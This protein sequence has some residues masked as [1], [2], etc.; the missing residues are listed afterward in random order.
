MKKGPTI[1]F[2]RS[3]K[4]FNGDKVTLINMSRPGQMVN[5]KRS[6]VTDDTNG[7][8]ETIAR[9]LWVQQRYPR[10]ASLP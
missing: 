5:P 2:D 4:R 7:K 10:W 3:R 1:S 9:S 8:G 6:L